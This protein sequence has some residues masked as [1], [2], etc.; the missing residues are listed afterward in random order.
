M[1]S[2]MLSQETIDLIQRARGD[3]HG[4]RNSNYKKAYDA[5]CNEIKGR[6]GIDPGAVNWPMATAAAIRRLSSAIGVSL[7]ARPGSTVLHHRR[8]RN[9]MLRLTASG[10]GLYDLRNLV[11]FFCMYMRSRR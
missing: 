6:P 8:G 11:W 9:S 5:I 3:G 1:S 10:D 2:F 4:D 7:R